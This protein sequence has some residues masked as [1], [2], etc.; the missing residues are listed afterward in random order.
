MFN[1]HEE[2][3]AK[4]AKPGDEILA[5]LNEQKWSLICSSIQEAVAVGDYLDVVKK[6]VIYGKDM[7]LDSLRYP[8]P[9]PAGLTPEKCHLLHMAIGI[10]GEAAEFLSCIFSHCLGGELDTEN[11]IEELGDLDFYEEGAR[12][13]LRISLQQVLSHNM[14]KLSARY[15][16]GSYSNQQAQERADKAEA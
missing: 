4:L 10:F 16:T 12:Q 1:S 5:G 6:H 14:A 11:A 9:V 13:E 2:M 15:S 8:I 3:V 7:G